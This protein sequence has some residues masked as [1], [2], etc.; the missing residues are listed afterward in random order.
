LATPAAPDAALL[1]RFIEQRDEAAFA[2]L[3]RRHGPMVLGVCRRTLGHAQDA[4]D[5]FQATFLVLARKA[6]SVRPAGA[7]AAWLHGVARRVSL[8]ARARSARRQSAASPPP[9]ARA[10]AGPLDELSAREL[11][12]AVDEELQQLPAAYRLP[13]VLCC[14]EGRSQEEVARQ[15]GWAPGSVKGRLERGRAR[16]HARLARRGLVPATALLLWEVPAVP[17]AVPAGLVAAASRAALVGA[18]RPPALA[19]GWLKGVAAKRA[20][21]LAVVLTAGLVAAGAAALTR[22]EPDTPPPAPV[23]PRPPRADRHGDPLP[24]G[25]L[26][27]LG[28]ARLRHAGAGGLVAFLADG[29]TLLSVGQDGTIHF[30]ETATGRERRRL[31][32]G[33]LGWTVALAPDEKT[34]A[35]GGTFWDLGTG[36]RLPCFVPTGNGTGA[37]LAFSPD[38]KALAAAGA[39]PGVCLWEWRAG[40]ELRRFTG[41][42]AGAAALAFSG[43]G[44]ALAVVSRDGKLW[45]WGAA[46]GE[47][48]HSADLGTGQAGVHALAASPDGKV[49]AAGKGR[50]VV[51]LQVADGKPLRRLAGHALPPQGLAFAP[52]SLTLA[53]GAG[54]CVHLWDVRSGE[55]RRKLAPVWASRLAFSR[56]GK[57]LATSG[58]GYRLRLWDTATGKELQDRGGHE[59]MIGSVCFSHDGKQVATAGKEDQTVR[60]WDAATGAPA[61]APFRHE[62]WVE[63]ALFHPDGARLFAGE[64]RGDVVEWGLA[65]GERRL[66]RDLRPGTSKYGYDLRALALSPD[67]TA[68]TAL[69]LTGSGREVRRSLVTWGLRPAER[70]AERLGPPG[71]GQEALSPDGALIAVGDGPSVRVEEAAGGKTRVALHG[72]CSA[73][74]PLAFA[75]DGRTLAG[76]CVQYGA[77]LRDTRVRYT[78]A[79]WELTTGQELHRRELP[80]R[81]FSLAFGPG[82]RVL[83]T[84]GVADVPIQLWDV[85]SAKELLRLAGHGA[86]VT[87]LAFAPDGGRLASGLRDTTTL[88]WDTSVALP[89]ARPALKPEAESLWAALAEP[90]AAKAYAALDRLAD[91]P[92]QAVVLLARRLRPAAAVEPRRVARLIAD[93]DSNDFPRRE[94]AGRELEAVR[95]Q[96]EASLREALAARPSAEARKRLQALLAEPGVVRSPEVV[97]QVRAVQGLERIGSKA[98]RQ[99]LEALT[100]GTSAAR[101]TQEA[102]ASRGRLRPPPEAP[103]GK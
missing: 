76:V 100:A 77:D 74:T 24:A 47:L 60:L 28:T 81:V 25:A 3:V 80:G 62:T 72:R 63:R 50:E 21:A 73:V 8:K 45:V 35:V 91:A 55:E 93:L 87:A 86:D 46:S 15:L 30:W 56:D 44:K 5:A 12:A 65:G 99:T 61:R 18:S 19:A 34:L 59:G 52:D 75:P 17:A 70:C 92:E 29:Q 49:L 90:E 69:G 82:G 66:R 43:D 97:R 42:R 98:A 89:R 32:T 88:V 85:A 2:A 4:E 13:L 9:P 20:A 7:L 94:A 68:L 11:V 67:G 58:A 22:P 96:A 33:P 16:L 31:P 23:G 39:E 41:P 6:A 79:L 40:K 64:F 95:D 53:V 83:A 38:G 26:Q 71:G 36:E 103:A 27:R 57:S 54:D 51:L 14:L 78:L 37:H 48:R 1:G 10:G 102:R 101:L 84:A